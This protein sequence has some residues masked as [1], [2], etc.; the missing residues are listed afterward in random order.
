MD[1][2][3]VASGCN[4]QG[5]SMDAPKKP[6]VPAGGARVTFRRYLGGCRG[7]GG[8]GVLVVVCRVLVLVRRQNSRHTVGSVVPHFFRFR[9]DQSQPAKHCGSVHLLTVLHFSNGA[10]GDSKTAP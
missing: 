2:P 4:R 7:G 5:L 6:T 1:L 8:V 9:P 10:Y 3:V